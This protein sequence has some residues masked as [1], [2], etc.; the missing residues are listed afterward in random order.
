[1]WDFWDAKMK[2][3]RL[4]KQQSWQPVMIWSLQDEFNS[5]N[6][7]RV[8]PVEEVNLFQKTKMMK[9]SWIVKTRVNIVLELAKCCTLWGGLDLM[10]II[11]CRTAQGI[12]M[13]QLKNII[14][15]CWQS[16]IMWKQHQ[17]DDYICHQKDI[18]MERIQ[19]LNLK[20]VV[21]ATLIVQNVSIQVKV[22]LGV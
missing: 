6:S 1:M 15:K 16:W 18:G 12:L 9:R 17:R 13:N 7:K 2:S 4:P 21:K 10:F 8:K 14:K 11:L 5:G 20:L 22:S 3:T 19:T